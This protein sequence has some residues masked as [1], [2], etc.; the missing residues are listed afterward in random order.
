MAAG[1]GGPTGS[2]EETG[3]KAGGDRRAGIDAP[4][5]VG[6]QRVLLYGT[7]NEY[8]LD[9]STTVTDSYDRR[10]IRYVL[11]KPS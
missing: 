2:D 1:G 5:W 9:M 11:L 4:T 10:M 8:A 7:Y 3:P 6:V